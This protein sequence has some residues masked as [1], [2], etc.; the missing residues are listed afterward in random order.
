[1]SETKFNVKIIGILFN[2]KERKILIG[3]NKGDEYFSFVDGELK[4]DE[5]LDQGLKRVTK[6]KTGHVIHNL[7]TIYANNMIEGKN[8][9]TLELYFLCEIN[10]GEEKR[11]EDVEEIRW[12]KAN[13]F[14]ELSNQKLPTRLKE[15]I[16]NICG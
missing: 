1:M 9:D 13:E 11:G 4:Y 5:E 12:I 10:G 16:T 8:T 3:K 15:Y 14:E 7:G 6:E 2:P